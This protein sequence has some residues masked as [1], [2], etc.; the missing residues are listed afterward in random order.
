M[1]RMNDLYIQGNV[2][3]L[4]RAKPGSLEGSPIVDDINRTLNAIEAKFVG[5]FLV[6]KEQTLA[7]T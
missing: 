2:Y 6:C 1:V 5:P 7:G 3:S 4:L